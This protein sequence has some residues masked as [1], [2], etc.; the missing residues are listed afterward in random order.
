MSTYTQLTYHQRYHIYS[1]LK[2]GLCQTEIAGTIGVHKSTIS[3]ELR[4]NRG[5]RDI[6]PNRPSDSPRQDKIRPKPG[7][8]QK[9]GA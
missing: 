8:S 6:G 5:R 7:S 4:R 3:R 1:L 9:I 2:A